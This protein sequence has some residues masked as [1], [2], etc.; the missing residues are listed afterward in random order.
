VDGK[1]GLAMDEPKKPET[2]DGVAVGLAKKVEMG[3]ADGSF[4]A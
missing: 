4:R 2:A 1:S 3:E